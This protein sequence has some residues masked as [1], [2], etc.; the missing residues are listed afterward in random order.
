[1]APFHNLP[2]LLDQRFEGM[3]L[4][5]ETVFPDTLRHSYKVRE[6]KGRDKKLLLKVINVFTVS[7]TTC[8]VQFRVREHVTALALESAQLWITRASM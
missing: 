5:S 6:M 3:K 2:N 4:V 1:M 8:E 7:L